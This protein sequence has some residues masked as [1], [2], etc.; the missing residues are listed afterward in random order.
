MSTRRGRNR[1]RRGMERRGGGLPVA[2][3]AGQGTRGT[4]TAETHSA[5]L[6]WE[7]LCRIAGRAE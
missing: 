4:S 6:A 3:P 5:T 7:R 2:A 1:D